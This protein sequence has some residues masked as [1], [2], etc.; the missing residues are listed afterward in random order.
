MMR[1]RM[2]IAL[3]GTCNGRAWPRRGAEAEVDAT[4]G[5]KMVA[6]GM[7]VEVPAMRREKRAVAPKAE[8]AAP[9]AETATVPAPETA[10]P[11]RPR[12]RPRKTTG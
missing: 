7:A 4:V 10:A 8:K 1:I 11:K 6:A 2:L 9:P 3:S 5:A 12:G